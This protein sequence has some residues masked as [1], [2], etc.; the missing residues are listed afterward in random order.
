MLDLTTILESIEKLAYDVLIWALLVPKTLIK[1]VI[2]P[3][4]V[5]G[6]V[7][8]E[9]TQ[10]DEARFD[11]YF[12]PIILIILT[13]LLPFVY[14]Y[15]TPIP[16]ATIQ[17][18]DEAKVNSDVD[19]NARADFISESGNFTY[20]WTADENASQTWQHDQTTDYVTFK[21]NTPGW[22]T[23]TVMA[24]NEQEEKLTQYYDIYVLDPSEK[25]SQTASNTA[26]PPENNNSI[27]YLDVL[28]GPMG[29]VATLIVL[30]IPL[31]FAIATESFRGYALTRSSLRRS[32]YIQCY[33]FAPFNLAIWSLLLGMLY[34]VTPKDFVF[35]L[36]T[37]LVAAF[38]LLWLIWNE[39]IA[40]AQERRIHSVLSFPIVLICLA[41]IV[42]FGIAAILLTDAETFRLFLEKFYG[43]VIALV[44]IAWIVQGVRRRS[45]R[46]KTV[47]EAR[48]QEQSAV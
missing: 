21:W 4:W 18:P 37:L 43:G 12:S 5:R 25:P 13:S 48:I 34:F 7:T 44:V 22:K 45:K 19:F 28:E 31:V 3:S 29:I 8:K 42:V 11:E 41:A 46:N 10:K 9:L 32:F 36:I 2:D 24:T 23:I 33:Y 30:S 1:I 17:G 20:V 14:S 39:T 27:D 16:A 35:N 40:I 6:Y 38:M 15:L 47:I 26:N